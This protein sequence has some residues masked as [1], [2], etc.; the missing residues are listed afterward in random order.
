MMVSA[1]LVRELREKSGAGIM[2]CKKALSETRGNLADAI[3]YLR[4]A[5]VVKAAKKTGRAASEGLIGEKVSS[6]QKMAVLVEVNCET[7]F[8]A[9]TDQFQNFVR[10]VVDVILESHPSDQGS[11]L[12]Q[13]IREGSLEEGLKM[14]ISQLGENMAI[15]R[16]FLMKA[17]SGERIGHYLHA[18]SKIGAL[19]RIRSA[20]IGEEVSRELAMHLAAMHPLYLDRQSVP[21]EVLQKEKE[22]L[23]TSPELAKKPS[24]LVGKIIEGKLVRYFSENC[25]L[26]QPFIKDTT[27]K[28]TVAGYLKEKDSEARVL[29]IAR[30]QVGEGV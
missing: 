10:Q 21:E 20:K 29:E 22:I 30:F 24:E 1:D 16:F 19:V 12:K 23:K 27:G 4:K 15:R 2:D 11:L 13:R 3:D 6:D 8:V 25:F 26:E 5:G 17:E 7:D 14:M 9:R 28:R 18:G